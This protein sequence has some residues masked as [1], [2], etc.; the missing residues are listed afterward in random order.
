MNLNC[1]SQLGFD[2]VT[3]YGFEDSIVGDEHELRINYRDYGTVIVLT[4][5]TVELHLGNQ[6]NF[7]GESSN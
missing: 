2:S 7:Y 3:K 1:K 6:D 5:I 4:L